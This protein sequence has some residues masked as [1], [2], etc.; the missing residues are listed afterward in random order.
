MQDGW[1]GQHVKQDTSW[2]VGGAEPVTPAPPTKAESMQWQ[3]P[4]TARNDGTDLWKSTLSGTVY[5]M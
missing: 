1:G 5:H 4:T 3:A 2:D